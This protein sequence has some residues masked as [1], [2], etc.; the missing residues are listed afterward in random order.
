MTRAQFEEKEYEAAFL[1]ELAQGSAP[2]G[3]VFASGQV[4]EKLVGYDAAARPDPSHPVWALLGVPRPAGVRLLPTLWPR[5][6]APPLGRLPRSPVS[7]ILQFKRPEWLSNANA[8]QWL[9]WGQ[10]YFRFRITRHQQSVLHRLEKRLGSLALVRYAAP[11]FATNS[12][13]EAAHLGRDTVASSGFVSPA[14]LVRHRIWTYTVPGTAGRANPR[15]RTRTFESAQQL[16][17]AFARL[18]VDQSQ[19]VVADPVA[20][21]VHSVAQVAGAIDPYTRRSVAEWRRRLSEGD[22]GLAPATL[23]SVADIATITTTLFAI[24]AVWCIVDLAL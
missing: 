5:G 13:L 7:L 9:F 19:L 20:D 21:H 17:Q 10:G 3:T 4:L 18:V 24:G 11:A 2:F 23:D 8:G 16:G 12:A 22:I 15:A 1:A 6:S 14:A